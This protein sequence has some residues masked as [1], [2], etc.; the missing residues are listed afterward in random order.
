LVNLLNRDENEA[1]IGPIFIRSLWV[2]EQFL[3]F[4]R[5]LRYV[6]GHRIEPAYTINRTPVDWGAPAVAS[7]G[8]VAVFDCFASET[9]NLHG[10]V[11]A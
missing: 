2:L 5:L 4:R 7:G 11:G 9:S 10:A 3:D 1:V 6:D 8:C